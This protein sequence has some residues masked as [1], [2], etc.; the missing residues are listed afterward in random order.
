LIEDGREPPP[1]FYQ[2]P[3][4]PA[5]NVFY[6]EA[7][8]DLSTERQIGMGIGPIPRSSILAYAA[9]HDLLGDAAEHFL[10][11]IRQI[12]N[13]YLRLAN[14]STSKSLQQEVNVSDVEGSRQMMARLKA[15]AATATKS[16]VKPAKGNGHS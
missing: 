2:Q 9:E 6:W 11:I 8:G 4:I 12:D 5:W 15:R 1:V 10:S 13:E 7:F 16:H 14:S 3:D